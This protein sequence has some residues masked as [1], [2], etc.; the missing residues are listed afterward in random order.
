M[1]DT[2]GNMSPKDGYVVLMDEKVTNDDIERLD[3]LYQPVMGVIASG[4]FALLKGEASQNPQLSN[5]KMHSELLALLNIDLAMFS[6]ARSA[7]EALGLLKSFEKEDAIGKVVVYQ[8]RRPLQATDFFTDDLLSTLLWESIGDGR[9]KEITARFALPILKLEGFK[10][11]SKSFLDVFQVNQDHLSNKPDII[12][13]S[14]KVFSTDKKIPEKLVEPGSIESFDFKFFIELLEKSFVSLDKI[15]EQRD[16]IISEHL[17]YGIDEIEMAQFIGDSADLSTNEVDYNT[18]KQHIAHKYNQQIKLKKQENLTSS[19]SENITMKSVE[20]LKKVGFSEEDSQL[21]LASEAYKPFDFLKSLKESKGGY[22]TDSEAYL[23]QQLVQRQIFSNSVINILIH[24]I[25]IDRDLA[26]LNKSFVDTMANDWLQQKVKTPEEAIN[27][28]RQFNNKKS[29]TKAS[30]QRQRKIIKKE[31]L[32]DWAKDDYQAPK[33]DVK[34]DKD[35]LKRQL[36]EFNKTAPK[37]GK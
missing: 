23:L 28:V 32:P 30:N 16:L 20:T 1:I 22:V 27:Q 34:V 36:A 11:T 10:E 26:T 24:Y 4:L 17:L 12:S 35:E 8:L 19:D 29:E 33:V 7:L 21:I 14:K 15:N 9:Y 37:G 25:L 3:Y 31:T 18:F 13:E 2:W 5:R 6:E